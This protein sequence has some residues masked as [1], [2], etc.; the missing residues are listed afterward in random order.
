MLSRRIMLEKGISWDMSDRELVVA[1]GALKR[2]KRQGWLDAGIPRAEVES[3]ADHSF[4]VAFFAAFLAPSDSLDVLK[5]VRM[6]LVHDLAEAVVGDLTP[7]S[8]VTRKKKSRMEER[9]I[10]GLGNEMLLSLWKEYE[11]GMTPEARM[12]READVAERV[13]QALEYCGSG[14]PLERLAH[15]LRGWEGEVREGRLRRSIEIAKESSRT[16]STP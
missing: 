3:V 2:V 15:F 16:K 1:A 11:N 5:M 14:H 12:V 13:L 8:G 7:R 9:I 6:A 10:R 4:R